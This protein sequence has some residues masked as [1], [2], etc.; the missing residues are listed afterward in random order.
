MPLR[1]LGGTGGTIDDAVKAVYYAV[2]NGADISAIAAVAT[3]PRSRAIEYARNQGLFIAAAGNESENNDSTSSYPANYNV[4]NIT[5]RASDLETT[6][7]SN[8]ETS[9]T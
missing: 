7:P 1:F 3:A 5:G 8:Y 6:R 9:C 4:A 2:D